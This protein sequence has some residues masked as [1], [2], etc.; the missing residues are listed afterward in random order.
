MI[1]SKELFHLQGAIWTCLKKVA[2]TVTQMEIT[3]IRIL[4]KQFQRAMFANLQAFPDVRLMLHD[5]SSKY[6]LAIITNGMG[7]AQRKKLAHLGLDQYFEMI[8]ASADIGSGKPNARIFEFAL[9]SMAVNGSSALMV[10]DSLDGDIRG[11]RAVG[12]NTV[13]LNRHASPEPTRTR[14]ISGF[15][16]WQVDGHKA[17][18]PGLADAADPS[19]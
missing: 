11:A 8:I 7:K 6:R 12:I 16:D 19:R 17:G 14:Q 15:T 13:W 5:V 3:C 9:Q 4:E 18:K 10:G 1:K 2:N